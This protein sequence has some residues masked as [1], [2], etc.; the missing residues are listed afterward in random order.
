VARLFRSWAFQH[1]VGDAR[2]IIAS[3]Q[4]TAINLDLQAI[5]RWLPQTTVRCRKFRRSSATNEPVDL[6]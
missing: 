6:T 4:F 3:D 5:S 1:H 2:R